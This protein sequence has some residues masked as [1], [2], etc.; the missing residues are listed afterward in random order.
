MKPTTLLGLG[1]ALMKSRK[2]KIV[3]VA[4]QLGYLAYTYI[5]DKQEEEHEKIP[6]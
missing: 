5:K 6:Q 2:A 4:L 1:S 3:F